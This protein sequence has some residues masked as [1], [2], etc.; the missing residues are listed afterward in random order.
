MNNIEYWLNLA[1]DKCDPNIPK[2]LIGNKCDV[3]HRI[4]TDE[5]AANFAKTHGLY[6]INV[7]AKNNINIWDAVIHLS[8]DIINRC[9]QNTDSS[10]ILNSHNSI[11]LDKQSY[12]SNCCWKY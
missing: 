9:N 4:I 3:A 7:S 11:Q 5:T 2:I 10:A 1:N 6:Y 12:S 8:T